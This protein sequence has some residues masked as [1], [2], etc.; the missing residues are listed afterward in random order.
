[1]VSVPAPIEAE[2]VRP[3]P[4]T[5]VGDELRALLPQHPHA[6][7]FVSHGEVEDGRELPELSRADREQIARETSEARRLTALASLVAARRAVAQFAREYRQRELSPCSVDLAHRADGK[8]VLRGDYLPDGLDITL[9]DGAGVSIAL[10][11]HRSVGVDLETVAIRDCET[12]R[13][14]LGMDG[15]ALALRVQGET[16]EPFDCAAT[17]VWT[18][19][20]AG[21]KAHSLRRVLTQLAR[22]LGGTWLFQGGTRRP[23]PRVH[24]RSPVP[25]R[26]SRR[27]QCRSF[28]RL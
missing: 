13:G 6:L 18:L 27:D 17:R 12:W 1:M 26:R 4:A 25:S 14:L 23:D 22:S 19:L 2:A 8:P 5:R 3:L 28:R 9:A 15:Y 24:V 20:E 7:V 10:V 21:K 16:G 11:G